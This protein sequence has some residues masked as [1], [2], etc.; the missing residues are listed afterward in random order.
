MIFMATWRQHLYATTCQL[1][2]LEEGFFH[3]CVSVAA[4]PL[5][6]MEMLCMYCKLQ[7]IACLKLHLTW[8][9]S[10]AHLRLHLA[11]SASTTYPNFT[12]LN[13]LIF[14]LS[15]T[16]WTKP[17]FL[18]LRIE[19]FRQRYLIAQFCLFYPTP[20]R[21]QKAPDIGKL[22]PELKFILIRWQLAF[23][24][25]WVD[26]TT[27]SLREGTCGFLNFIF[28]TFYQLYVE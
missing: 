13:V 1:L 3:A 19:V 5:G 12:W 27:S 4:P 25:G 18:Q 28:Q 8:S 20:N 7:S 26:L 21:L 22:V 24:V 14:F 2:L 11:W 17:N 23:K 16:F 15:G 9:V 6:F 10:I